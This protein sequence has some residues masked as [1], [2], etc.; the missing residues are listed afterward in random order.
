MRSKRRVKWNEKRLKNLK[1]GMN[2]LIENHWLCGGARQVGKTFLVKDLFAKK[3]FR[4]YVYIDLKK[5][6]EARAFFSTTSN[7]DKYLTYIEV[8]YGKKITPKVPLIFDEC[9]S[10]IVESD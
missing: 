7:A 10:C 3:F 6:D 9:E 2:P 4:D 1:N 8:R 5:D